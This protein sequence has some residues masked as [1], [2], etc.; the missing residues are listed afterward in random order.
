MLE[1]DIVVQNNDLWEVA[2]SHEQI[3]DLGKTLE[4]YVTEWFYINLHVP[5]RYG[6]HIKGLAKGGDLDVVAFPTAKPVMVECKTSRTDAI[7][8]E[9][10]HLFLQRATYFKPLK[11][12][13]LVDTDSEIDSLSE[14]LRRIYVTSEIIGPFTSSTG[15]LDLH[16][17]NLSNTRKGLHIAL[18][19]TLDNSKSDFDRPLADMS[20]LDIH[21]I[22]GL[23]PGMNKS[24]SQVL[25]M[26]CE[27]AIETDISQVIYTQLLERA[28]QAN[29]LQDSVDE[30]I[31]MLRKKGYIK[32]RVRAFVEVLIDGFE[33]YAKVYVANYS[34][35]KKDVASY[36]INNELSPYFNKFL[37]SSL[38][39]PPML[40]DHVLE[41]FD[42][43][44]LIKLIVFQ[45]GSISINNISPSLRRAVREGE[46]I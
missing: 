44:E 8:D 9:E 19:S 45:G 33:E 7:G 29:I 1:M 39:C 31:E 35:I 20:L 12:L 10:L 27:I 32:R 11:A 26:T 30:A 37:A 23:I 34:Q 3:P 4:W 21:K 43:K 42:N 46:D 6:V 2:L 41:Y 13:L 38:N 15:N 17:V 24:D 40:I 18:S 22:A 25:K 28:E 36:I 16:S 14:R 5:A